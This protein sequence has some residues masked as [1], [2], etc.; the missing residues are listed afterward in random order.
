MEF[1]YRICS[2]GP[3][4]RGIVLPTGPGAANPVAIRPKWR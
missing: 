1:K 3:R 4:F 2:F